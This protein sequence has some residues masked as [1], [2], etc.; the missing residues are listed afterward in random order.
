MR[1]WRQGQEVDCSNPPGSSSPGAQAETPAEPS[2][3]P[4]TQGWVLTH[5]WKWSHWDDVHATDNYNVRIRIRHSD[6]SKGEGA[7]RELSYFLPILLIP[8]YWDIIDVKHSVSVRCTAWWLDRHTSWKYV[9]DTYSEHPHLTYIEH[10][11]KRKEF[12][13]LWWELLGLTL[14]YN[15]INYIYHVL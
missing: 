14:I 12:S 6:L 10:E 2:W 5:G 11:R 15:G 7:E 3:S 1:K 9:H 13:S 8:F 4:Y